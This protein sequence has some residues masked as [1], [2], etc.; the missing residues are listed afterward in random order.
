MIG[1]KE[2]EKIFQS[3]IANPKDP[4][5]HFMIER[6][7]TSTEHKHLAHDLNS[8]VMTLREMKVSKTKDNIP[9][10]IREGE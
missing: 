9:T 6:M 4:Y 1:L 8:L 7:G 5:V 3:Q 2:L 10:F